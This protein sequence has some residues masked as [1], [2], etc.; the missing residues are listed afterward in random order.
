[1][2]NIPN[3]GNFKYKGSK[4]GTGLVYSR[5][6]KKMSYDNNSKRWDQEGK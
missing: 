5:R 4:A 1:M 2:E 3:E 6:K